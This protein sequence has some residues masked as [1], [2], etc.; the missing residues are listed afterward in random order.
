MVVAWWIFVRALLSIPIA[1]VVKL[2]LGIF[3]PGTSKWIEVTH[4]WNGSLAWF[5]F[6]TAFTGGLP[7]LWM[8]GSWD[9]D[10]SFEVFF[11]SLWPVHLSI[12]WVVIV[13]VR[14][15]GLIR[16][17]DLTPHVVRAWLMSLL[18]FPVIHESVRFA[19]GLGYAVRGELHSG[20]ILSTIIIS[21]VVIALWWRCSIK[22]LLPGASTRFFVYGHL[23]V[24]LTA[25]VMQIAFAVLM[26]SVIR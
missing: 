3:P 11:I 9:T 6:Q 1:G 16:R 14:H 26:Q 8:S 15:G 24:L 20:V 18:I 5:C 19:T 12:A 25:T 7:K 21:Y 10:D 22:A 4:G 2:G 17:L 23:A 13:L